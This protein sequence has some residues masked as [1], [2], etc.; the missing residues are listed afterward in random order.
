MAVDCSFGYVVFLALLHFESMASERKM[1]LLKGVQ[2][3]GQI[4]SMAGILSLCE[5]PEWLYGLENVASLC[6]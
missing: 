3:H 1:T 5:I 6:Q 2:S 4:Y